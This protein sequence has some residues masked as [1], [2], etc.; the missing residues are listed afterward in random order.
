MLS[1]K[2]CKY[3]STP[4][5]GRFGHAAVPNHDLVRYEVFEYVCSLSLQMRSILEAK[6]ILCSFVCVPLASNCEVLCSFIFMDLLWVGVF[7]N[8]F[9]PARRVPYTSSYRGIFLSDSRLP[10]GRTSC[11][12]NLRAPTHCRLII[13]P[14]GAIFLDS[15]EI[16][17]DGNA[18]FTNNS[19]EK[20]GGEERRGAC[21]ACNTVHKTTRYMV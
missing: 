11:W 16:G 3:L 9:L 12:P 4:L 10:C 7:T 2:V 6:R 15:S 14:A 1:G 21:I 13:I 8:T 5:R 20:G 17:I 19:A 18:S